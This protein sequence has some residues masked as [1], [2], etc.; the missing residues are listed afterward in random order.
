MRII[1]SSILLVFMAAGLAQ[2]ARAQETAPN[3]PLTQ[4]VAL[5]LKQSP[6]HR[7][8]ALDVNAAQ[9]KE[10]LTKTALLPSLWFSET[11]TRGN[12]PVYVFGARLRQQ[13]FTQGDL[14]VGAEVGR[15]A[16]RW[17]ARAIACVP[18]RCW[19]GS[20]IRR[21]APAWSSRWLASSRRPAPSPAMRP[22]LRP[23][24]E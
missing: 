17:S 16:P 15:V 7:V 3:G 21:P 19:C 6:A 2:A 10:R 12:D 22:S 11:A 4:S 14:A 24:P 8:A 9:T 20:I 23:L 1:E 13:R 5:A 18:D